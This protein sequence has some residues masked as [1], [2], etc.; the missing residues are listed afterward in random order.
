MSC[1]SKSLSEELKKAQT[2][3]LSRGCRRFP[4]GEEDKRFE[5]IKKLILNIDQAQATLIK[6][7]NRFKGVLDDKNKTDTDSHK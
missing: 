3:R 7:P 2:E 1:L 5:E 4:R 6:I